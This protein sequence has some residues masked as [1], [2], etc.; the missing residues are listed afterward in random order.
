MYYNG[1]YCVRL[2]FCTVFNLASIFVIVAA[3]INQN[4]EG[5]AVMAFRESCLN[6]NVNRWNSQFRYGGGQ[7]IC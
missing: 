4:R 7:N 3:R 5:S 1:S 2:L 6:N